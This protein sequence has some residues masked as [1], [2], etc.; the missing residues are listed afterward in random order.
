MS[1]YED[2]SRLSSSDNFVSDLSLRHAIPESPATESDNSLDD[3]LERSVKKK[4][5]GF[6]RRN[7]QSAHSLGSKGRNSLLGAGSD[8]KEN[9]RKSLIVNW[10]KKG[11][12]SSTKVTT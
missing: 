3:T 10:G 12:D 1:E 5:A 8:I 2:I 11:V 6:V 9:R 7:S 4:K